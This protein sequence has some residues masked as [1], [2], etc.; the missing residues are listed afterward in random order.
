M[1]K[2]IKKKLHGEK[3]NGEIWKGNNFRKENIATE[4]EK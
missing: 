3:K 4:N 1:E 2:N